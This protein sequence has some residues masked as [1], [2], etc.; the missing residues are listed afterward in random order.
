VEEAWRIVEP[1]LDDAT[2]I[3][4]YELG[5]WGPAGADRLIAPA[6]GWFN[7]SAT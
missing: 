5:S 1:V 2:P 4:A 7:P 6:G 3:E